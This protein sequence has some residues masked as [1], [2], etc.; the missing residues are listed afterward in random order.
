MSTG[1]YETVLVAFPVDRENIKF[2]QYISEFSTFNKV[3]N[4][5]W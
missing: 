4:D 2:F 1:K 5:L 3:F